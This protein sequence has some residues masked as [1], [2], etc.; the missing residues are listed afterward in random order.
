MDANLNNLIGAT[1]V[2][3]DGNIAKIEDYKNNY[4]KVVYKNEIQDDDVI[5]VV[6]KDNLSEKEDE[7]L[8]I[9]QEELNLKF[10]DVVQIPKYRKSEY[11]K[12]RM[13]H[14]LFRK[15]V[16]KMSLWRSGLIYGKDH[17][18]VLHALKTM[19]NFY[20]TDKFFR[21]DF[22]NTIGYILSNNKNA[23]EYESGQ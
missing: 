12:F 5:H 13:L 10:E 9:I 7:F 4:L 8:N 18:T 6:T 2:L 16:L 1:I 14:M 21:R 11:V 15:Q 19:S 17:C 23:F 22:P 20:H 3:T